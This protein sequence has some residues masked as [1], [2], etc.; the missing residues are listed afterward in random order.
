MSGPI[1]PCDETR[2]MAM[3]RH[4]V[5]VWLAALGVVAAAAEPRLAAAG[6]AEALVKLDGVLDEPAWAN[7]PWNTDFV[8]A[9][10]SAEAGGGSAPAAAQT[11][12]KVLHHAD[13]LYLGVECDE[14]RIESLKASAN[15]HDSMVFMDDCV[16]VFCDPAGQGRYYYHFVVNTKGAWYDNFGADYGVVHA[17]LWEC[18]L[19]VGTAVDQPGKRWCAE[20][21]IPLAALNLKDAAAEWLFNVTRERYAGG[22]ALPGFTSTFSPATMVSPA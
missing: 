9:R 5:M 16:E 17:K 19:A 10:A 11:R 21:G 2:E 12:F 1:D 7:L 20:I 18:P 14:P 3:V 4:G 15:E 8:D 22:M 6:R 13:W